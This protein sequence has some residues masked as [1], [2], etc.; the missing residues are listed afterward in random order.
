MAATATAAE[1]PLQAASEISDHDIWRDASF[2]VDQCAAQAIA[3][4]P[5]ACPRARH[6]VRPRDG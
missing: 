2:E 4:I 6:E 1:T 5:V 3:R